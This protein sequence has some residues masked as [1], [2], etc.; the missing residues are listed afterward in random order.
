LVVI[1][2]D[3]LKATNPIQAVLQFFHFYLLAVAMME[4]AANPERDFTTSSRAM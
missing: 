3:Q 1:A 2:A 4:T